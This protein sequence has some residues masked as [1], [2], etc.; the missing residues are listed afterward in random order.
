MF[1]LNQAKLSTFAVFR[2]AFGESNPSCP[3]DVYFVLE[4]ETGP[5]A[6]QTLS[7]AVIG[8]YAT[9]SATRTHTRVPIDARKIADF[10]FNPCGN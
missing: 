1:H 8:C 10:D 3:R 9:R 2:F 5:V 7:G 6:W 4:N